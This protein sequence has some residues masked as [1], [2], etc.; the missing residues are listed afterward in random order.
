MMTKRQF[1]KYIVEDF[2]KRELGWENYNFDKDPEKAKVLIC[3]IGDSAGLGIVLDFLGVI[4]DENIKEYV[5]EREQ[6]L[7]FRC[8]GEVVQNLSFREILELLPSEDQIEVIDG[9]EQKLKDDVIICVECGRI[10]QEY[11]YCEQDG[12]AFCET[13]WDG[14]VSRCEACYNA[15]NN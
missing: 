9:K 15:M 14:H 1:A 6:D 7:I 10:S 11:G 13:C 4:D 3:H 5:G 8:E 2:S 12:S